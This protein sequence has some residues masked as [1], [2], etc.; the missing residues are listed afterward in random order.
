M[1]KLVFFLMLLFCP[2]SLLATK[3]N[4]SLLDRA[5][6]DAPGVMEIKEKR[7]AQL[8]EMCDNAATPVLKLELLDKL[9]EEYADFRYDSAMVYAQ[10][11]HNL[12]YEI[13]DERHWSMAMIRRA[14]LDARSGRYLQAK[15]VLDSVSPER[16]P[17][18]LLKDYHTT[19][20]WLYLY[21]REFSRDEK[22]EEEYLQKMRTSLTEAVKS[23]DPGSPEGMF[24]KAEKFKIVDNNRDEALRYYME[25]I[26]KTPVKS[27]LYA[28]AAYSIAEHY[29]LTDNPELYEQWLMKAAISD[30]Q[31]PLKENLALQEL[32]VYLHKNRRV[33][34]EHTMRYLNASLQDALFFG[35][36]L[37]I[38]EISENMPDIFDLYT[39]DLHRQSRNAHIGIIILAV[40][41]LIVL[42]GAFYI[43]KQHNLI[44]L[45]NKEL[46]S[47]HEE[48]KQ[49]NQRLNEMLTEQQL[50]NDKLAETNGKLS[51]TID[52]L[53]SINKR[54]EWLAKISFD[55]C[56]KSIE[57]LQ[58]FALTVK[59]KIKAHQEGDLLQASALARI[60]E[61]ETTKFLTQF[62]KA[63]LDLY[64][65]FVEELNSLLQPDAQL[66]PKMPGTLNTE[67]RICAF[68]RL[69]IKES[70]EIASLLFSPVQTIYN[71]RSKVKNRAI[72]KDTFE[73]DILKLCTTSA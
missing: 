14:L 35:N 11:A 52:R 39:N 47:Q 5:L 27:K 31:T 65:N 67:L 44:S 23:C 28:S 36:R 59:R 38:L 68:I 45:S 53:N 60:P 55:I 26:D 7:I 58:S 22:K 49:L 8:R 46:A 4:T 10:R 30:L 32:A 37:R 6:A 2:L 3:A 43:K 24:L 40:L 71:N 21:L 15:Q 66:I 69:G 33:D 61:E 20:F 18:P 54:R 19:A 62:D 70:S 16:L 1:N 72:N 63:F 12:A 48:L 73:A 50:S 42:L 13:G 29:K 9:Y 56:A 64:P 34:S 51:E 17:G 41:V 57:K 25:V